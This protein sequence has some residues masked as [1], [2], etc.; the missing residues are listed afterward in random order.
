MADVAELTYVPMHSVMNA[1]SMASL[2]GSTGD[3]LALASKSQVLLAVIDRS[4]PLQMRFEPLS[5]PGGKGFSGDLEVSCIDVT[6]LR[7]LEP[8][9]AGDSLLAALTSAQVAMDTAQLGASGRSV[10]QIALATLPAAL[11]A[12]DAYGAEVRTCAL[13]FAPL[14][15]HWLQSTTEEPMLAVSESAGGR[16]RVFAAQVAP[17]SA[18]LADKLAPRQLVEVDATRA[19]TA[20]GGLSL[21]FPSPVLALA[22]WACARTGWSA[23]VA[24]CEDGT[25]E[26]VATAPGAERTRRC[27]R[28]RVERPINVTCLFSG[29][30]L[31]AT[32]GDLP[33]L[34]L[35][36]GSVLCG[37]CVYADVLT[38][39]LGAPVRALPNSESVL[40]AAPWRSHPNALLLGTWSR[41]LHCLELVRE[42]ASAPGADGGWQCVPVWSRELP[43]ALYGIQLLDLTHDGLDEVVVRT[44]Q[45]VHV[46]QEDLSR[47]CVELEV[48]LRELLKGAPHAAARRRD[49]DGEDGELNVLRSALS[50]GSAIEALQDRL[51]ALR[52]GS[53][54]AREV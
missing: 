34:H 29:E 42:Q 9:K 2:P 22:E 17:R 46:L 33:T 31:S 35:L 3:V 37:A 16:L 45:G 7:L 24:G 20:L 10:H 6:R 26:L 43:H 32:P 23:R 15:L 28:I 52:A 49:V 54:D 39:G 30:G 50:R 13:D 19:S 14:V 51:S 38:S 4:A 44:L 12:G 11:A 8:N 18:A 48:G 1:R 27:H 40:C 25:L 36:I 41:T 21:V 47:V 53:A 5:M